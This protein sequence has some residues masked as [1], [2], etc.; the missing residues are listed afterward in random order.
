MG[1]V[2]FDDHLK[3]ARKIKELLATYRMSEDLI[4]I[5]A[6]QK[7]TNPKTDK[8]ILMCDK[9]IDFLKQDNYDSTPWEES[10]EW[11]LKLADEANKL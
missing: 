11:L 4:S 3:A 6:Y 1:K 7:G 9:I 10:I 2:I 8:A 5:G